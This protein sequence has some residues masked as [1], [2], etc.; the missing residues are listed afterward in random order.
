RSESSWPIS[1]RCGR[2]RWRY[3]AH[4]MPRRLR[5]GARRADTASR[6][7]PSP[8]SSPATSGTTSPFCG[9]GTAW[10]RR[11]RREP[12]A[13][14]GHRPARGAGLL[15][16]PGAAGARCGAGRGRRV[17]RASSAGDPMNRLRALLPVAV[18]GLTACAD[19]KDLIALQRGLMAEFPT[20]AINV[21]LTNDHLT[22]LLQ[23]STTINLP[24]TERAALAR[25]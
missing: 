17:D 20:A 11:A 14:R 9:S 10:E 5:A 25:R 18:L 22:V 1:A 19:F 23:D 7:G 4:S 16:R 2:P 3:W 12:P 13:R 8:T 6:Y 21:N 24:A 15:P